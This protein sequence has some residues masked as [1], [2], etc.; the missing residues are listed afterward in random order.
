[1]HRTEKFPSGRRR[2]IKARYRPVQTLSSTIS[3]D[4]LFFLELDKEYYEKQRKRLFRN[5]G[6]NILFFQHQ[7]AGNFQKMK[8]WPFQ[9]VFI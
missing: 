6:K 5:N 8:F 7:N 1:M 2:F 3:D 4:K 9:A